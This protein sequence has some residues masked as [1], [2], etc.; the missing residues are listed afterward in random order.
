[1]KDGLGWPLGRPSGLHVGNN[2]P[3]YGYGV[4]SACV[5]VGKLN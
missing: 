3:A 4:S 1:M 5:L 2:M